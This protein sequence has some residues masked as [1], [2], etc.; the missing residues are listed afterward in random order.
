MIGAT[1][2]SVKGFIKGLHKYILS[3]IV[4]AWTPKP[5]QRRRRDTSR[6]VQLGVGAG[7]DAPLRAKGWTLQRIADKFAISK[8]RVSQLI[9]RANA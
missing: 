7:S 1:K 5:S 6:S 3:P 2:I 4:Q 8:Q 9:G